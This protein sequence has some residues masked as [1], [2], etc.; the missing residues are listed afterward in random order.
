[1]HRYKAMAA[2]MM[3]WNGTSKDHPPRLRQL[4]QPSRRPAGFVLTLPVGGNFGRD[5]EEGRGM[6][7][8][9]SAQEGLRRYRM[10]VGG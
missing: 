2:T 5:E 8:A 9:A 6:A 4:S 10:Y 1:M 7:V 3:F